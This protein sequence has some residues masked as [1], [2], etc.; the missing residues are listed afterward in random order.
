MDNY[1]SHEQACLSQ[2]RE[3]ERRIQDLN[4]QHDADME[5]LVE[6]LEAEAREMK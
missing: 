1:A 3:F 4:D 6:E 2:K 5:V